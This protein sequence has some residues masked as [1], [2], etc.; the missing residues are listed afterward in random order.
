MAAPHVAGVAALMKSVRAGLTPVEFDIWLAA[1]DL[2]EDIGTSGRD[3]L[4]G[5]GLIDAYEAVV[6]AGGAP[7]TPI[8]TV[9]PSSLNFGLTDV[10]ATLFADNG[11][12]GTLNIVTVSDNAAWLTVTATDVD[13]DNLGTY[14]AAVLRNGLADGT[15]N[16]T[17][18]FTSSEN[19]V[20][21]PLIMQVNT[22]SITPDTGY[23]Y[24]QLLYPQTFEIKYQFPV[25]LASGEYGYLCSSVASGEYI[26]R[27]GS[28]S[29]NNGDICD[30]GEAC[31]AYTTLNDPITVNVNGNLSGLD[32]FSSFDVSFEDL[33][34]QGNSRVY[35]I[36]TDR[37]I[38]R[39]W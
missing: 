39:L 24:V 28:D 30:P 17:I 27:A 23:H 15:Y 14:T 31:G 34:L 33:S 35:G 18:T 1:G 25:G 2:T 16:A 20:T 32:F 21:V 11:G 9:N 6:K 3:D 22:G 10:F 29:N 12:G 13:A 26:I 5:Y 7:V 38:R 8:L 37:P 36:G 4:F 19:V